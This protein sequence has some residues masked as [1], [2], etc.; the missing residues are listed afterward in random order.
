MRF[1]LV[2][3]LFSIAAHAQNIVIKATPPGNA[4]TSKARARQIL[5]A[6]QARVL[7]LR[8][9]DHGYWA[10]W[11]VSRPYNYQ[12]LRE[13][14][15]S[16]TFAPVHL[17][18][19]PPLAPNQR[20]EAFLETLEAHK[21]KLME[22]FGLTNQE[23]NKIALMGVG[24]L[25]NESQFFTNWRYHVKSFLPDAALGFIRGVLRKENMNTPRSH[26]GVQM[27][28]MPD[29]V[30]QVFNA[31][32]QNE[33]LRRPEIAAVAV[34]I[35]LHNARLQVLRMA[36]QAGSSRINATNVWDYVPYIYMGSGRKIANLLALPAST[37]LAYLSESRRN[38][39]AIPATNTYVKKLADNMLKF[40]VLESNHFEAWAI[41]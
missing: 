4:A 40:L 8:Q 19:I 27:K 32:A 21:G 36:R 22:Y 41:P 10:Y 7:D 25:G 28:E 31:W 20:T 14:W 9:E 11:M 6:E 38:E 17:V 35:F 15:G 1:T 2:F 13:N 12:V 18:A 29:S 16:S 3:I 23:Y 24:I 39:I 26:G 34:V 5:A 37:N 33:D 30:R